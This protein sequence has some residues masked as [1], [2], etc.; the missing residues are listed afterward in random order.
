MKTWKEINATEPI[1][2]RSYLTRKLIFLGTPPLMAPEAVS[3]T[4][5]EHPEWDM[6]EEKSYDEWESLYGQE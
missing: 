2:R 4:A 1:T 6:E 5:L 3:S